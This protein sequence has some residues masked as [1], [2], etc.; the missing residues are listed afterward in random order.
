MKDKILRAIPAH[1]T[2]MAHS[3]RDRR[4]IAALTAPM[5]VVANAIEQE[6]AR[7]RNVRDRAAWAAEERYIRGL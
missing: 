6:R 3:R 4:Q 7:C 5:D 2:A 1:A